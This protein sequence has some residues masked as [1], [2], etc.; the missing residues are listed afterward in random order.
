MAFF[1]GIFF[2]LWFTFKAIWRYFDSSQKAIIVVDLKQ[3][4]ILSFLW[5]IRVDICFPIFF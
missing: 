4:A 2:F 5:V 3:K 1:V